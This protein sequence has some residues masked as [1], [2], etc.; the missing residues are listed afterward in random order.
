MW[1]PVDFNSKHC[2]VLVPSSLLLPTTPAFMRAPAFGVSVGPI[3]LTSYIVDRLEP[4]PP[5]NPTGATCDFPFFDPLEAE[6][7]NVVF[8]KNVGLAML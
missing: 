1:A 6:F 3:A 8:T 5:R 2:S 4:E 7:E